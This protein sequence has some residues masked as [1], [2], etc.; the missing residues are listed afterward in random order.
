MP[1]KYDKETK[2]KA[3]RLVADHADDYA[4]EYE[5]IRAVSSRLG[6]NPETLRKWIRQSEVDAGEAE[7]VSTSSLRE[8]RELKRKNAELERT[9]EI[10]KAATGFLR[11]GERPA[12]SMMCEFIIEHRGRFGVVP[13]CRVLSCHGW[14]IAPNTFYAWLKRP[15]SKRALWDMTITEI[16]SG[17]YEPDED[18][19]RP[20]ESLYGAEKMWAHL[21]RE[22]ITVARCT[23]ERLM[24]I[25]GW[26]GV[27]RGN[28]KIR[29]TVSDPDA[30]RPADLVDRNWR[31][32][33]P[34]EL[35]VADFTYVRMAGGWF[36]YTSF[37]VD[38][39]ADRIVG[40]EC[41]ASK[42]T[43]LVESAVHQAEGFRAR[44]DTPIDGAIHHSDHGSQYLSVRF[45]ETLYLA[46]LTPSVGSVGD[47]YDNALCETIIGLYKTECIRADSPF[48]NRPLKTIAD[49]E[50]VTSAWVD[51][52]NNHRLMHRL[53]RIPPAEHEANHYAR[54]SEGQQA[55]PTKRSV[56]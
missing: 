25:N 11:A 30:H 12:T 10:L 47:A 54:I 40:W 37:C 21:N 16:L 17:Y 52:Y 53:G 26:H 29:T 39:F 50:E 9:V 41:S 15:P 1:R 20:P 56:H 23:I 45:G 5:A 2:A 8:I 28:T 48:R 4:S 24:A 3:V 43:A 7:G 6:M 14:R 19:R 38:A 42:E 44:E 33:A 36:A 51:W 13:I 32:D 22:G 46:G 34:N 31:V 27:T 35:V 18:R 55:S 49:L